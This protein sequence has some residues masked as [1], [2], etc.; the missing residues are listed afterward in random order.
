MSDEERP[1]KNSYMEQVQAQQARLGDELK[2]NRRRAMPSPAS[3]AMAPSTAA[4]PSPTGGALAQV[5]LLAALQSPEAND[6]V[7]FSLDILPSVLETRRGGGQQVFAVD[8]YSGVVS[9]GSLDSLVLTEMA[10]DDEL[11]EQP[12]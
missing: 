7:N 9:N 5:D 3:P 11:F 10:Y 1:V 4:S 12:L 6:V 2:V 8:G